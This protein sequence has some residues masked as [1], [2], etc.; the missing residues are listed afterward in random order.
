MAALLDAV[1]AEAAAGRRVLVF[2]DS[3]LAAEVLAARWAAL[4]GAAAPAPLLLHG[5]VA[6]E[7]RR[8]RLAAF[9]RGD[10]AVLLCTRVCDAA[11]DFPP[12]CTVVQAHVASGSRQQE[13]QR[14]GRG[15]RGVGG[16][17]RV[18]HLVNAGTCEEAYVERRVAHVVESFGAAATSVARRDDAPPAAAVAAA[19]AALDGALEDAAAT[20][21]RGAARRPPRGR[22][23]ARSV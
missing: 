14:C 16:A 19:A 11:I 10:A 18:V 21:A 5:G 1:A 2:S 7:Q 6:E 12:D 3:R 4:A 17:S 9:A 13:V 22:R 15:S 23:R 20:A 8:L